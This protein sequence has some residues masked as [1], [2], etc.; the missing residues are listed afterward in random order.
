MP[1]ITEKPRVTWEEVCARRL[2][3]HGLSSPLE[4]IKLPEITGMLCGV[5]AQVLSAAELSIGLRTTR[6]KRE[7]IHEALWREKSLVKA[8]GPRGTV[9]LLASDD[10]PMWTGALSAIP[11]SSSSTPRDPASL[12]E[13]TRLTPEQTD[14]IVEIIAD[15]LRHEELTIEEL[16]EAVIR[17]AGPWADDRVVPAFGGMWPRWRLALPIAGIR[18]ALCYG[19]SRGRKVTYISPERYLPDF[20]PMDG[21]TALSQ[22]VKRFLLAYGPATPQQFAKWLNVSPLWSVELFKAMTRELQ[23]VEV[24]GET[25]WV[26]AGD[27]S[28]P[29]KGPHGIRLLPYFDS[30]VVG[31]HPRDR[32]FPG[33]AAERALSGGQAGNFPVMLVNGIAAGV[34]NLRK[35]GRKLYITVEPFAELTAIQ[36]RELA[37][38]VERIGQFLG[39]Q[40]QLTIGAVTTGAHA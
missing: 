26:V 40:P 2:D 30:Y 21:R 39:G 35:A 15:I 1:A 32:I 29:S 37:D 16:G 25:A 5:H 28:F 33:V 17:A 4:E 20:Q 19:P 18:G 31:C 10:L 13:K 7:D 34:W 22:V 36:K 24:D 6:A 3:R 12:P 23:P 9:H 14:E 27:V 38:Q 8:F 11:L